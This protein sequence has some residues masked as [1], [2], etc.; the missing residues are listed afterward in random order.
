MLLETDWYNEIQKSNFAY[1]NKFYPVVI[2]IHVDRHI[3]QILK[4]KY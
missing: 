1:H 3:I 2:S 4:S